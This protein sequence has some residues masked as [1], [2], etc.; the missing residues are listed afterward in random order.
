[1]PHSYGLPDLY[2]PGFDPGRILNFADDPISSG[3]LGMMTMTSC[4][5]QRLV[6]V[7]LA[8]CGL[9]ACATATRSQDSQQTQSVADAA[10]RAREEKKGTAKAPT[11]KSSKV[12]TDDDLPKAPKP[13]EGVNVGAPAKLETQ[14]PTQAT[15]AAVEAADQA[16]A[17]GTESGKKPDDPEIARA[18]EAVATAEK[19]LDLLKRE[20]AL[21]QDTFYSNTDYVHD[22]VG[23]TKLAGEQQAIN[24]KQVELEGLKAKLQ[25]IEAQKKSS[26]GGVRP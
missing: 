9:L 21:D 18:K 4:K 12:I 14:P 8:G 1:L 7:L 10:R 2:L 13:V 11:A 16:A 24:N 3:I 22:K 19:E 26:G 5:F 20:M 6:T 23:Q 15:V 25:E 17:T